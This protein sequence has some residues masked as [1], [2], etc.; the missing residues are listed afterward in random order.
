MDSAAPFSISAFH[1]HSDVSIALQ[2][3]RW[4]L[5]LGFPTTVAAATVWPE[6]FTVAEAV[7]EAETHESH[8]LYP[9]IV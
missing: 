1:P 7:E 8:G 3:F 6:L 4:L 5:V 2:T 9:P